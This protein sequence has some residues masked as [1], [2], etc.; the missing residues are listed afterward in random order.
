MP[1]GVHVRNHCMLSNKQSECS[2]Y[3]TATVQVLFFFFLFLIYCQLVPGRLCHTG[4]EG[5]GGLTNYMRK[6]QQGPTTDKDLNRYDKLNSS[7]LHRSLVKTCETH[8]NDFHTAVSTQPFL[9]Y[10]GSA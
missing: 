10:T 5:R 7:V 8:M 4:E 1:E 6:I 3:K 2:D 9:L